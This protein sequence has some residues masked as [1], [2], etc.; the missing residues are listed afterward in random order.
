MAGHSPSSDTSALSPERRDDPQVSLDGRP[1]QAPEVAGRGSQPGEDDGERPPPPPAPDPSRAQRLGSLA[2]IRVCVEWLGVT[3][4]GRRCRTETG[5]HAHA[6]LCWPG[7]WPPWSPSP[8]SSSSSP[9]PL[10]RGA[11]SRRTGRRPARRHVAGRPTRYIPPGDDR[12]FRP[13]PISGWTWPRRRPATRLANV[14]TGNWRSFAGDRY[15]SQSAFSDD[16]RTRC[17]PAQPQLYR[18]GRHRSPSSAAW[19]RSRCRAVRRPTSR[20]WT[21]PPRATCSPT[22]TSTRCPSPPT[23]PAW[24]W[25]AP[26]V[27]S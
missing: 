1:G 13:D 16:G 8:W 19:T 14:Q 18:P 25:A 5:Q 21:R 26:G 17:L 7:C 12:W 4:S 20:T 27:N 22:S 11:R 6:S 15:Q 23:A 3:M 9:H 24:P 2:R 10:R